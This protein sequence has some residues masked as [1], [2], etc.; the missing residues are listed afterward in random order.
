MPAE[1]FRTPFTMP[2]HFPLLMREAAI[3]QDGICEAEEADEMKASSGD[4]SVAR[5]ALS[6][7]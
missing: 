3:I 2:W 7:C 5:L 4:A 1:P 6:E